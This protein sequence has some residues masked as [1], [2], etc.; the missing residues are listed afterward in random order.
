MPVAAR[1]LRAIADNYPANHPHLSSRERERKAHI[2][3]TATAMMATYGRHALNMG[4]FAI[5][6]RMAPATIRRY[7]ADL[8]ALLAEILV[9]HLKE[10]CAAIGA[11]PRDAANP[12]AAQREAY[13]RATRTSC[14]GHVARHTLLLRDRHML[15]PDLAEPIE[16]FRLQIGQMLAGPDAEIALAL[17]DEPNLHPEQ[18]EAM[19]A[20]LPQ[21]APA[22][23]PVP[24]P[25]P[26]AARRSAPRPRKAAPAA[27]PAQAACPEVPLLQAVLT[28]QA[29]AGP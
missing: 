16:Q 7:F 6:V 18:I 9:R 1:H 3:G 13:I 11:A 24:A 23:A 26:A 29:R 12:A 2:V 4:S 21:P 15:P 20:A 14:N 8:D 22:A 5:A 10:V 17:L 27:R 28:A 19:L 25:A